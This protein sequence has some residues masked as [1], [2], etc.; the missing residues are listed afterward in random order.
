MFRQG[1]PPFQLTKILQMFCFSLTYFSLT[2]DEP[3][4]EHNPLM[5]FGKFG[6]PGDH[7]TKYIREEKVTMY[8]ESF[9]RGITSPRVSSLSISFQPDHYP[10][11][12][13]VSSPQREAHFMGRLSHILECIKTK[14]EEVL[15]ELERQ[16]TTTVHFKP[17]CSFR[18]TCIL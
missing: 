17:L 14:W 3:I 13:P 18:S 16:T 9:V 2:A 7:K 8:H 11:T 10:I 15:D 4:P 1:Y 6:D 5:P 12:Y